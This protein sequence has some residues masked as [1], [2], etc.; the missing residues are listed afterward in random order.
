M[1]AA[2]D[3]VV[4][5]MGGALLLSLDDA[6]VQITDL[7]T[8]YN[9]AAGSLT[10]TAARH[11]AAGV[12]SMPVAIP[13]VTV[14]SASDTIVVDLKR[15]QSFNGI[16]IVGGSG[17]D[18][19]TIG[20]GGVNLRSVTRGAA[21]QSLS[22]DTGAG[23]ADVIHVAA[24]V[25]S[26]GA[27]G[28]WLTAP[29]AGV[30][31]GILIGAAVTTPLGSQSYVGTVQVAGNPRL[32]AG[33]D[34][35]FASTVDGASRLTLSAGAAV[36]FAGAI[37]GTIPL[38][39][40]T[41]AAA[42]SVAV[43]DS[44]HLD[45]TGTAP[46]TSG[47]VIGAGVGNVVF[48]PMAPGNARTITGFSG[49][50]VHLVGEL[51]GSR[52][53]NLSS[54]GNGIGLRVGP[55]SYR[56]TVIAGNV[57]S[58]NTGDG[59]ALRSAQRLTFGTLATGN[60]IASN[61][62]FG[63]R[64]VG[65]SAGSVARGN[66]ISRNLLGNANA[67]P[68]VAG[69]R[70][71]LP[72]APGLAV[73]LTAPGLAATRTENAGR[74]GF[75]LSVTVNGVTTTSTG[76]VDLARDLLDVAVQAGGKST[77]FRQIGSQFY[78]FARRELGAPG[79]AWVKL[80]A[81]TQGEQVPVRAVIGL[82]AGLAPGKML[83]ALEF[84]GGVTQLGSDADGTHYRAGIDRL[85]FTSLLPLFDTF[86]A[87]LAWAAIPGGDGQVDVWVD[88]R[89]LISRI[90]ASAGDVSF[91]IA[92]RDVGGPVAVAA[93]PLAQTGDLTSPAGA[94]LFGPGFVTSGGTRPS[95]PGVSVVPT[96]GLVD[97]V[98]QGALNATSA[99]N[100]QLSYRFV[101]SSAGGKLDRGGVPVTV[102][103]TDPQSFTILP[104][105]TWLDAGGTKGVETF[106]VR[107]GEVT[108]FSRYLQGIPLIGAVAA[109][110]LELLQDTPHVG[111]LLAP[112]IG[113]SAVATVPVD[114]AALAPGLV[115]LAF[116]T[117]TPSFDGTLI[118][119]N[120]FPAAGL[121]AGATAPTVL[122]GPGL[123]APG[124]TN[125]YSTV[126]VRG[127]DWPVAAATLGV[128]QLRGGGFNVVTWDPRGE[129]ASGGTLQLNNPFYEGRDVSAI[130]D[131]VASETPAQLN[132]PLDPAVGMV[133]GSYGGGI[134]LVA[135][136]TDPRIDAIVPDNAWN[137]LEAS[138]Y[139]NWS[140]RSVAAAQLLS[141]LDASGARVNANLRAALAEGITTGW[142][143]ATSQA[144]LTSSG[145]TSLLNG[146]QAPT[147]L[148]QSIGNALFPLRQ[149][150]DNAERILANPYGT[151]VKMIWYGAGD[152]L[153]TTE[154]TV[155][156]QAA[157]LWLQKY[158]T[159]VPIPDS[160]FPTFT[161]FDAAGVPSAAAQLP[162]EAGFNEP[163]PIT[164]TGAGG[165][166]SLTP[167]SFTGIALGVPITLPAGQQVVGAPSLSF[168]YSG[169]GTGRALYARI[170]D[171]A[172]GAVIGNAVTP[173]P[174]TLDGTTRTVTLPLADIVT[175]NGGSSPATLRL[176]LSGFGPGFTSLATGEVTVSAITISLPTRAGV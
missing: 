68:V 84:P 81:A 41:V 137:S 56:G 79:N 142:L 18:S 7:H 95:N 19:I 69:Q 120:F 31:H 66:Q 36:R 52:L 145:P 3:I 58:G 51:V 176:L 47:L 86:E 17:T 74:F 34:I 4:S 164:A 16:R 125:P 93:P 150:L 55:G 83:S 38:K 101:R 14:D 27:G 158:V 104:Y 32:R 149:S 5:R 78:V 25:A 91:T 60:V 126:G 171:D 42:R 40:L 163:T 103:S 131:W 130:L 129:F 57:F 63:I 22:I 23:V 136:S 146:L 155:V 48:S 124:D 37:G 138:L 114:V 109:P 96:V 169:Q 75:D 134:Q 62:G 132:G 70:L 173:I 168:T 102:A 85:T 53:T 110:V 15:F 94:W 118:S 159:G 39:G 100:Q 139:P 30:D 29:A 33:G 122:N 148:T 98:V 87:P 140:F 1:L 147:L 64:A 170:M 119:T 121:A 88:A 160:A 135:A 90:T 174:V 153:T 115:P 67:A 117:M 11:N 72:A 123:G 76:R 165:T 141:S 97:G 112:L 89:G 26:K 6:G 45:G 107:V 59:V 77:E 71:R 28:V 82:L 46:G 167:A 20:P 162:F 113:D 128:S 175:S 80:D 106:D 21:A 166:L 143:S 9:A 65:D 111:D 54:T 50:G 10:V 49:S 92:L 156:S 73:P 108:E 99:T 13:G 35:A 24:P 133:G 151:P 144:T 12:L 157:L 172:T 43:D 116:T 152:Q 44:L 2:D 154:S 127:S 161:Y 8:S 61:G 105:A